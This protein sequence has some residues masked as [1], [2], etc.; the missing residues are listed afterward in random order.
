MKFFD[1][2]PDKNQDLIRERGISF[3]EAVFHITHGGLLDVL[4]HP[5]KDKYPNQRLFVVNIEGYAVLVPFVE[6]EESVFLKTIIPS[7]KMAGQ[8]LGGEDK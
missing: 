3:E 7:R 6:T 2:N 1:W 4:E 5:N 8:Y